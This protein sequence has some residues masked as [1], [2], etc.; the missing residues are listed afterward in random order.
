MLKLGALYGLT[1]LL[2][3]GS[4]DFFAGKLSRKIGNL[5]TGFLVTA[6]SLFFISFYTLADFSQLKYLPAKGYLH[7]ALAALLQTFGGFSFYKGLETGKIGLVS[8]IASPW[9]II[10]ILYSVFF[11]SE[12]ITFL[13]L[14]AFII[15]LAGTTIASLSFNRKTNKKIALSDPGIIYALLALLGW[16]IGFIFLNQAISEAGWLSSEIMFL[17]ISLLFITFYVVN[18]KKEKTKFTLGDTNIWKFSLLA[19]C[20]SAL[21]YGGYSVGIDKYPKTLVAPIAAAYPVTTIILSYIFNKEKL[22]KSQAL[23]ASLVILG[24]ALISI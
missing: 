4:A 24:A 23:G 12:K 2:S 10:V 9:S 5:W 22:S 13:Q 19:G 1:A 7:L 8:A 16:G 18:W 15:I 6:S 11:L 20:F 17:T 21:A 3:W 14:T